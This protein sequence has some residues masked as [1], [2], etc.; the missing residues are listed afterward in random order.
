MMIFGILAAY[1]IDILLF[2]E[3]THAN[4]RDHQMTSDDHTHVWGMSI[5]LRKL[6]I[7]NIY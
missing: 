3:L 7:A 6:T 1:C 4:A 2:V 5:H